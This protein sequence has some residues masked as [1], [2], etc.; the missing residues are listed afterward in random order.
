MPCSDPRERIGWSDVEKAEVAASALA[1]RLDQVTELLCQA[2]RA[3]NN[4]QIPPVEVRA[5]WQEHRASDARCGR[6][7]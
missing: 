7:W 2:G 1:V 5:C 3:Y 4:G 6:P